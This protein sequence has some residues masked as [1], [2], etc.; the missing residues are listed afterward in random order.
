MEALTL[1]NIAARAREGSAQRLPCMIPAVPS[2]KD[3]P[4]VNQFAKPIPL[5]QSFENA[6]TALD[7]IFLVDYS[8][9]KAMYP[10][11]KL[12]SCSPFTEITTYCL[13]PTAYVDGIELAIPGSLCSHKTFPVF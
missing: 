5:T 4:L 3:S 7:D 10:P 8:N 12:L 6:A 2:R 13:F 1:F 11:L 9:E